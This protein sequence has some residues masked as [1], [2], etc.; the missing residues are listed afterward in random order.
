MYMKIDC[1][2]YLRILSVDFLMLYGGRITLSI[3]RFITNTGPIHMYIFLTS[4]ASLEM[5]YFVYD[6][7]TL[8]CYS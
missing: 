8:I 6:V 4:I 2:F 7:L 1:C 5:K 3:R